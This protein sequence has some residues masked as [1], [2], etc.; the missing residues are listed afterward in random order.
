MPPNIDLKKLR[1]FVLVAKNGGLRQAATELNLS[2]PAVSIQLKRLEEDL[3]VELF[4][5]MGR[6]LV[7]TATGRMFLAVAEAAL[8]A[9]D[10]A[11][12]SV[13]P[14]ASKAGRISLAMNNDLAR[15]FSTD[16]TKFMKGHPAVDI[17]LRVRGSLGTLGM[18]VDGD[19]D[20][21]IGYFGDVPAEIEKRVIGKSGFSLVCNAKHPL[22]KKRRPTLQDI[23]A[24]RII[25]LPTPTNMGQRIARVFSAAGVKPVGVVEAGNCQ[26]S[27]EFAEKDI[28]IAIIHTACLGDKWPKNLSRVDV[29]GLFGSVD[30]ALI[31]RATRRM[32][33]PHVD[34]LATIRGS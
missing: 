23:G 7:L 14:T 15:Y 3:G 24:H 10:H 11:I 19:V 25:T 12:A 1:A 6:R 22:A 33:R 2:M 5:R 17:S 18:V 8:D 21:G 31:H 28:G 4:E 20:I 30:I 16:I 13:S 9:F 32:S 29:S 26:T 34:F 27:R